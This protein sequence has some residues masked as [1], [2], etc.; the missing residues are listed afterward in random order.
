[1][2]KPI[3]IERHPEGYAVFVDA[4]ASEQY[5]ARKPRGKKARPD[6]VVVRGPKGLELKADTA[7]PS[8]FTAAEAKSV[9]HY[10]GRYMLGFGDMVY[11]Y[12][13]A[14]DCDSNFWNED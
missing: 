9:A 3:T 4:R 11:A 7:D 2:L 6:G 10:I 1:M 8:F 5:G 12:T 13:A 14:V